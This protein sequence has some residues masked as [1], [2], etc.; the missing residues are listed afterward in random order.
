M[1]GWHCAVC[2]LSVWRHAA[3]DSMLDRPS[4]R[5]AVASGGAAR[6]LSGATE[7]GNALAPLA[8]I[9]P[10]HPV[11]LVSTSGHSFLL[12][13][14]VRALPPRCATP[15]RVQYNNTALL[16]ASLK[17]HLPIVRWLVQEKGVDVTGD[18]NTVRSDGVTVPAVHRWQHPRHQRALH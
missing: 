13:P 9:R 16:V 15:L 7:Q 1:T 6:R 2:A 11:K 8:V 17:G 12:Q 5:R 18:R 4:E 10:T 3:P 14:D